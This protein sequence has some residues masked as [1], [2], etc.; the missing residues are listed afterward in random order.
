MYST[1]I[2]VWSC[3][4][5]CVDSRVLSWLL[6][7]GPASG[8]GTGGGT[9]SERESVSSCGKHRRRSASPPTPAQ[10]FVA[11]PSMPPLP[12]PHTATQLEE[13]R[14]RLIE[15][16]ARSKQTRPRS[17]SCTAFR[18]S[19]FILFR[20]LRYRKFEVGTIRYCIN[21]MCRQ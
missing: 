7:S 21:S 14:R 18:L 5:K 4:V 16:E 10:P 8:S 2:V 13:A 12:S 17:V 6:E 20:G 1:I 9:H 3:D 19:S 11:D 15:D